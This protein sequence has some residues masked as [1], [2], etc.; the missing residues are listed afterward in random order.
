MGE[1][2][3]LFEQ[4]QSAAE[5]ISAGRLLE[6]IANDE[7]SLYFQP[8]VH[9]NPKELRKLEPLVRWEHPIL[10]RIAPG[11]QGYLIAVR[12]R[13]RRFPPGWRSGC[14]AARER[15]R[16]VSGPSHDGHRPGERE[17]APAPAEIGDDA[18]QLSPR[19]FE[20]MRNCPRG[21]R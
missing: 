18:V 13:S 19:Q 16:K 17:A 20:V 1:L 15:R 8:T 7:P 2:Q 12:C 5:P 9:H 21:G 3:R 6:A 10:G 4:L 11:A 14:T